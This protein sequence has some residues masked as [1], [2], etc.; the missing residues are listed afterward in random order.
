[1]S[2]GSVFGDGRQASNWK[3]DSLS[4]VH[5]G[6][7]DPTLA[8]GVSFGLSAADIRA[9]SLIGWD[10]VADDAAPVPEPATLGLLASGLGIL[11]AARRRR[12]ARD[13]RIDV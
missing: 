1:M 2:T 11:A 12:R 9:L 6:I 13:R 5:L 7:M 3:D 4:G 8:T 10:P